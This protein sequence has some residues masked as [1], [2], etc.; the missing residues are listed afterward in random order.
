MIGP[1]LDFRRTNL[2]VTYSLSA[3]AVSLGAAIS[4][5]SGG[6]GVQATR[7]DC[8]NPKK[9]SNGLGLACKLLLDK[10]LWLKSRSLSFLR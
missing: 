7:A 5:E 8:P 6:C 9:T 2:A 10:G 3:L 4:A 1:L